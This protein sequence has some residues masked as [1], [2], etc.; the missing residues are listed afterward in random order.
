MWTPLRGVDR[1]EWPLLFAIFLDLVG[2]GMAFIDLQFRA[3]AYGASSEG[4]GLILSSYSLVQL[5][6]SPHWEG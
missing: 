5:V 1:R 6:V 3:V 4:V 2:F